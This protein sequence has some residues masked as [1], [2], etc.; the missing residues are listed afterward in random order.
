MPIFLNVKLA[1]SINSGR[2]E[3][4]PWHPLLW[5]KC[6]GGLAGWLQLGTAIAANRYFFY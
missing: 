2:G 1:S 3:Q 6:A 4:I 5:R